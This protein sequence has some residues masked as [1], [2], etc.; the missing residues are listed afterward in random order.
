MTNTTAANIGKVRWRYIIIAGVLLVGGGLL[1]AFLPPLEGVV[2]KLKPEDGFS[3]F[4]ILYV[5]AQAIER[6]TQV[7]VPILDRIIAIGDVDGTAS[8]RK[9]DAVQGVR[10]QNLQIRA[11]VAGG[12]TV[13][14][15]ADDEKEVTAANIEKALLTNVVAL[16][17]AAWAVGWFNFSL[18]GA[19]GFEGVPTAIDHVVTAVAIM[20]GTAGLADLI[21][22]IQKSKTADEVKP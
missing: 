18:L 9:R 22:K 5:L 21:S 8:K 17:F 20:G 10:L 19:I 7:F 13:A 2:L 16:A 15:A 12:A 11:A 1:A 4:A 6:L 3:V 14:V